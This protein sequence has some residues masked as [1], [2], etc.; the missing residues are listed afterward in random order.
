MDIKSWLVRTYLKLRFLRTK[1]QV[2]QERVENLLNT[3]EI[4]K[5]L[6]ED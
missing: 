6:G 5:D 3:V 1:K 4:H 2:P